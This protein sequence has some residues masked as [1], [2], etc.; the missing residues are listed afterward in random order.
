MTKILSGLVK[1]STNILETYSSTCTFYSENIIEQYEKIDFDLSI[2]SEAI[3]ITG[4]YANFGQAQLRIYESGSAR[5]ADLRGYLEYSSEDVADINGLAFQTEFEFGVLNAS[6]NYGGD[7]NK[8][9]YCRLYN[10]GQRKQLLFS[11]RYLKL[12]DK[13]ERIIKIFEN[14]DFQLQPNNTYFVLANSPVQLILPSSGLSDLD[15]I[16][17]KLCSEAS[18]NS[19]ISYQGLIRGFSNLFYLS[20]LYE[21]YEFSYIGGEQKWY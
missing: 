20:K 8:K 10:L 16:K 15:F 1:S 5:S 18:M 9:I 12:S 11:I 6:I 7:V 2:F 21:T 4:I 14:S 3:I 19:S 17:I 13:R